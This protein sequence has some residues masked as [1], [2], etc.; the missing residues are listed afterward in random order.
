MASNAETL[1]RIDVPTG[2]R[3]GLARFHAIA[4]EGMTAAVTVAEAERAAMLVRSGSYPD[5]QSS[6]GEIAL[7]LMAGRHALPS[8]G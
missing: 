3:F 6:G 2:C 5:G 8:T 4:A 7:R 1:F